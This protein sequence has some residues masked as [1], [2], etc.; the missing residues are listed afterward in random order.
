MIDETTSNRHYILAAKTTN[1]P[2]HK[3][4]AATAQKFLS[5]KQIRQ[6]AQ[7][8]RQSLNALVSFNNTHVYSGDGT[9]KKKA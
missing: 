9:I 4:H 8:D 6:A 1:T 5:T 7:G 3:L 2:R